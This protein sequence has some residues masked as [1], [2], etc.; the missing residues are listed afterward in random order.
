MN[1]IKYIIQ[2][3]YLVRIRK[4]TFWI[5]TLLGPV[6]YAGIFALP[7]FIQKSVGQESQV[8]YVEDQSGF[9][10]DVLISDQNLKFIFI[11]SERIPVV[12]DIIKENKNSQILMIHKFDIKNPEGFELISNKNAGLGV[13]TML[14][15]KI[16][17]A[18]KDIRIKNLGIDKKVIEGLEPHI[19]I[20]VKKISENGLKKDNTKVAGIVAG[21]T[22]FLNYM[23]IF[24]YGSLILRGVQEEKQNRIVEI[25]ISSIRPFE[26]MMGKIVGVALV[27]LTQFALWVILTLVFMNVFISAGS[28]IVHLGPSNA[29]LPSAGAGMA[30]G[31]L[32]GINMPFILLTFLFYFICGYLLYASLFASIAAAVDNQSDMQQF[33]LPVTIPLILGIILIP[34]VI[35]NPNNPLA[36]VLSI[37]PFTSPVVMMA[38]IAFGVPVIQL[39]LSMVLL[40]AGFLF[41]AWISSKIYRIGILSYGTKV[42]YRDLWKWLFYK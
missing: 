41:I 34:S 28:G 31:L 30:L 23:F 24:L 6:L 19:Q 27:G 29:N 17:N 26:L 20:D 37:V 4:K 32:S 33:M 1:K 14:T 18:I 39:V 5:L 8:I 35:E 12:R 15:A 42:G 10:N 11:K 40:V 21:I 9:F 36:V 7:I 38:R 3:E 2:R 13:I 22:A 25:I 16:N